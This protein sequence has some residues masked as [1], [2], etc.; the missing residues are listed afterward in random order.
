MLPAKVAGSFREVPDLPATP[1]AQRR[2][3]AHCK[4]K[5]FI[6]QV[7]TLPPGLRFPSWERAKPFLRLLPFLIC[8]QAP[9]SL[10][11]SPLQL[12]FRTALHQGH[13]SPGPRDSWQCLE[14]F[15]AVTTRGQLLEPCM[16]RQGSCQWPRCRGSL[17]STAPVPAHPV[18]GEVR[19]LL[20]ASFTQRV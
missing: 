2:P 12:S 16:E 4:P 6:A 15:L 14:L 10:K 18:P 3:P 5:L 11:V 9:P 20:T 13:L 17:S 8:H 7:I 19:G 1:E